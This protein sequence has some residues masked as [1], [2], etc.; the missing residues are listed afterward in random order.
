MRSPQQSQPT[1]AA[2]F[3]DL[4]ASSGEEEETPPEAPELRMVVH[5]APESKPSV[6]FGP[7][8]PR[9]GGGCEGRGRGFGRLKLFRC[10]TDTDRKRKK[11]HFASQVS[12]HAHRQGFQQLPRSVPVKVEAWFFL[13]RPESDFVNRDRARGLKDTALTEPTLAIKPDTDNLGKF[14]LDALT[15]VVCEDDAQVVELRLFKLRDCTGRCEGRTVF[16]VAAT[17]ETPAPA[18][19]E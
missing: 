1:M 16:R 12:Q 19:E 6:R 3:L 9:G 13:R 5:M 7:A 15:G 4:T 8:N 18:F 10:C 11:E 2:S 14:L 17:D